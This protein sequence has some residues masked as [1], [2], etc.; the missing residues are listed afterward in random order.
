M[1]TYRLDD[2]DNALVYSNRYQMAVPAL[3]PRGEIVIVDTL[4]ADRLRMEHPD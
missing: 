4:Q 2:F 3:K 1:L